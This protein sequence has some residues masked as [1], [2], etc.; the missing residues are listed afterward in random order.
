MLNK[1]CV[2]RTYSAGVH[3]GT[4]IFINGTEALLKNSRRLWKWE[5]AFTLSEV[6]QAGINSNSKISQEIPEIFLTQVIEF[7]PTTENA[8]KSFD[9]CHE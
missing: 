1:H 7:L 9:A 6:S 3:I 8:R 2:I 4:P 5:G